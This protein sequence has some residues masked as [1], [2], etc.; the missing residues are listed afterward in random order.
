LRG[1]IVG[2]VN[3]ATGCSVRPHRSQTARFQVIPRAGLVAG[4]S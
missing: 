2:I 1:V 4:P 3:I